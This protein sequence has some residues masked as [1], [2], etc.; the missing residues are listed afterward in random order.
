MKN[1]IITYSNI[2]YNHPAGANWA[3]GVYK[4]DIINTNQEYCASYTTKETFGGDAR[5]CQEMKKRGYKVI[6]T[7]GVYPLQKC[8]GVKDMQDMES[9]SF[10]QELV[11][12]ISRQK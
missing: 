1:I 9:E 10:I 4:V 8:V 6:E 12:F 3:H 2:G 7:R 5:F 11:D